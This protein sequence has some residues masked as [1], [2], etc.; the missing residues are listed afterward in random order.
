[1]PYPQSTYS[2]INQTNNP[3][4]QH[5]LA[6]TSTSIASSSPGGTSRLNV[7]DTGN[8][9]IHTHTHPP[10]NPS[11]YARCMRNEPER[12]VGSQSSGGHSRLQ[13]LPNF[14]SGEGEKKPWE[15]FTH[16]SKDDVAARWCHQP[17]SSFFNGKL[18]GGIIHGSRAC[19]VVPGR[20]FGQVSTQ[21]TGKMGTYYRES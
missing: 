8:S 16:H 14:R 2:Q 10:E 18:C 1:M 7:A 19:S 15:D 12:L 9:P 6:Q 17:P 4:L 21:S 20:T 5:N 13:L 3:F 11:F